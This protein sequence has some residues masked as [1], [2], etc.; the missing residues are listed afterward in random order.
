ME[1]AEEGVAPPAASAPDASHDASVTTLAPKK[2]EPIALDRWIAIF[3]SFVALGLAMHTAYLD[4]QYRRLSVQPMVEAVWYQ[5]ADGAGWK[6]ANWGLGPG[7]IRWFRV[8]VDGKAMKNWREV[9]D[10]LG[11]ER[12]YADFEFSELTPHYWQRVTPE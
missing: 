4:R 6:V 3:V 2:R 7:V 8:S 9:Y 1:Q 12:P 11:F 10:A 5:T